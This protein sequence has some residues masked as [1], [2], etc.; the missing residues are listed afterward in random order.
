MNSKPSRTKDSEDQAL[1][2]SKKPMPKAE[3]LK[4]NPGDF[5]VVKWLDCPDQVYM[6]KEKPQRSRG[7]VDVLIWGNPLTSKSQRMSACVHT[8]VLQKIGHVQFPQP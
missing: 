5:I 4:L 7:D 6:V 1:Y 8:Q 2:D 3:V